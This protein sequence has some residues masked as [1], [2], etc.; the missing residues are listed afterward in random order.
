MLIIIEGVDLSGKTTLAEE[1][2]RLTGGQLM[3]KSQP[4]GTWAEE[5]V[6]P[7]KYY[8]PTGWSA[9]DPKQHIIC[10]RWHLGELVYGPLYRDGTILGESELRATEWFLQEKGA[11]V[12]YLREPLNVIMGRWDE[13]GE[14]FLKPE[15]LAPALAA[16]DKVMMQSTLPVLMWH[17]ASRTDHRKIIDVARTFDEAAARRRR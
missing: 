6:D 17:S 1:L 13:R 12:V 7:L 8:V 10:D 11:I 14:D 3:H 15:H 4:V 2:Q 9:N 5:Y 16:Y